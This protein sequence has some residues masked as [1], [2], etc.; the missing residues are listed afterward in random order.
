MTSFW[1]F[2][3]KKKKYTEAAMRSNI[4]SRKIWQWR[5]Q[6]SESTLPLCLKRQLL[7][8]WFII[9]IE[10]NFMNGVGKLRWKEHFIMFLTKLKHRDLFESDFFLKKKKKINGKTNR[11]IPLFF[12]LIFGHFLGLEN[13]ILVHLYYHLRGFSCLDS[14]FFLIQ[15][16][17]L[18]SYV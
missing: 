17:S 4:L 6:S 5:L 7:I 8:S 11:S 12:F 15:K 3:K 9:L 10:W 1:F 18:Y 16:C 2:K 13:R 14:S